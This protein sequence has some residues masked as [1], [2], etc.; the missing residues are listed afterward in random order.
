MSSF[1]CMLFLSSC[2]NIFSRTMFVASLISLTVYPCTWFISWSRE[3]ARTVAVVVPSPASLTVFLAASFISVAPKFST[4]L[5]NIT[6][7]A[8]VTPSLVIIGL[9]IE[10]SYITHFPEAPS[11]E[12][13][14]FDS[15]STP[16][17]ILSLACSPKVKSF[18]ISLGLLYSI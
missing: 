13:T 5:I 7:S 2:F 1:I 3:C 14:A 11:V 12:A 17:M 8:T 6:D 10:S 9:P 16:C 15:F 4:G 18:T